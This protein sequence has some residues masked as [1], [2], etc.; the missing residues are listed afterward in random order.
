[1]VSPSGRVYYFQIT[2]GH[3]GEGENVP[4]FSKMS[5]DKMRAPQ[6]YITCIPDIGGHTETTGNTEPMQKS[7][8]GIFFQDHHTL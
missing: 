8:V 4:H 5:G 1:M 7:R 2:P 3:G 6:W